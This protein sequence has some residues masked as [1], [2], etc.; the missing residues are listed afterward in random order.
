M[1]T[2]QLVPAPSL[3]LLNAAALS[4]PLAVKHLVADLTSYNVDVAVIT[5]THFK[6]KHSDSVVGV[7]GYIV[8][9]RDRARR[10]GG[11]VALYVRSNIQSTIWMYSANDRMYEIHWVQLGSNTFV[12]A[13]YHLPKTT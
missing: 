7:K 9:H 12:A 8:F 10:R 13:L 4:K 1:F 11:G 2:V 3:Y 6:A 5:E